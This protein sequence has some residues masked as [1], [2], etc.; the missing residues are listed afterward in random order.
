M[1]SPNCKIAKNILTTVNRYRF[2]LYMFCY[3]STQILQKQAV[4]IAAVLGE[5][6]T[7]KWFFRVLYNFC[8]FC[9]LIQRK[10]HWFILLS[11]EMVYSLKLTICILRI[12]L[13]GYEIFAEADGQKWFKT[14]QH[15]VL[16]C[17]KTYVYR[18][19]TKTGLS[20]GLVCRNRQ[21]SSIVRT[22]FRT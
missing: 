2:Q 21:V 14:L 17:L 1:L 22:S 20:R 5:S 4:H 7:R 9:W 11:M 18:R 8:G 12:T 13:I 16:E 15:R 10:L 19:A 3:S 6:N